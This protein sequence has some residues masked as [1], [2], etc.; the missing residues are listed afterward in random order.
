MNDN[1]D[2]SLRSLAEEINDLDKQG[3]GMQVA[4]G[5]KLIAVRELLRERNGECRRGNRGIDGLCAPRGWK[6]WTRQNLTISGSQASRCVR[7]AINP[8]E[9]RRTRERIRGGTIS[10][11][12]PLPRFKRMWPKFTD[13]GKAAI[14]G[15]IREEI[16][17]ELG[18]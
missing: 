2:G 1:I 6:E 7:C 13:A 8:D 3:K 18:R 14:A 15:F 10:L 12:S 16:R 9:L 5:H 4:M 11:T 17:R